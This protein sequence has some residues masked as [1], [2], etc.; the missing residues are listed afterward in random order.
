MNWEA[1]GAVGELLGAMVVFASV[2]YL[3][4]Q[5]RNSSKISEDQSF[6]GMSDSWNTAFRELAN[7][8]NA[9]IVIQGLESFHRL[10]PANK[11]QFDS[12]MHVLMNTVEGTFSS[13][14]SEF[15]TREAEDQMV[16]YLDRFFSYPG[17]FEWWEQARPHFIARVREVIDRQYPELEEELDYWGIR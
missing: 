15:I 10:E 13:M 2:I 17:M 3:A 11:L 16:I 7:P 12:L 1:I 4:V 6:R 14:D 5:I 9:A 8:Q